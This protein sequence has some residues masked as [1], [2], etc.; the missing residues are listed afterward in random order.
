MNKNEYQYKLFNNN[1]I[2]MLSTLVFYRV[3]LAKSNL[4]SEIIFKASLVTQV[5]VKVLELIFC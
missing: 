2:Q 1:T 3:S 5:A 4:L